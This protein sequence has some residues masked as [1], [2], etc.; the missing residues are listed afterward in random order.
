MKRQWKVQSLKKTN[1]QSC[2][3]KGVQEM[4]LARELLRRFYGFKE[5]YF[6]Y[7][8][9]TQLSYWPEKRHKTKI[10]M[11]WEL[12]TWY[13][14]YGEINTH[15]FLYGFDVADNDFDQSTYQDMRSFMK[16][17][18]KGNQNGNDNSQVVLLRDKFLFNRYMQ[19]NCLPVPSL[20]V[21]RINGA[22]L[23]RNLRPIS[24]DEIRSRKGFFAKPIN[25]ECGF[26]VE[27]IPDYQ[28]FLNYL[29]KTK[30]DCIFQDAILQH[31]E[32]NRLNHNSVNSIRLVTVMKDNN[33]CVFGSFLRIGTKSSGER[34]NTS[35][36]GIAVK[37]NDDGTLYP[38]GFRKPSFGGR[39]DHHPES[40]IFFSSFV[41]PFYQEAVVAALQAHKLFYRMKSIGWDIAITERGPV[42]IEGNDN[43][44][45]QTIQ[46]FEGGL[47]E[48]CSRM[49]GD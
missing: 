33:P 46:A 37:I 23:D 13:M 43:W 32:M 25:G 9:A 47:R 21:V 18:S 16:L 48:R 7:K 27:W 41:I 1:R 28:C 49:L 24:E 19:M 14:R 36:G 20:V 38:Y 2:K 17:R 39:T 11:L 5:A 30:G 26:S 34:D 35:Q 40:G 6:K 4:N 29:A 22:I 3:V 12:L 45:L 31:P 44:E 8:N 15:Y 10:K 42:F